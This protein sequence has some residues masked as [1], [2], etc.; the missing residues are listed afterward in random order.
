MSKL[1]IFFLL[2]LLLGHLILPHR[3]LQVS[4]SH[5]PAWKS[6][7]TL[8]VAQCILPRSSVPPP[9]S[10]P[11]Q[12]RNPD[13]PGLLYFPLPTPV[14]CPWLRSILTVVRPA[15][16]WALGHGGK[17]DGRPPPRPRPRPAALTALRYPGTAR[18]VTART[19][20]TTTGKC[21]VLPRR[22]RSC[23]KGRVCGTWG[24]GYVPDS[25][26]PGGRGEAGVRVGAAGVDTRQPPRACVGQTREL[27]P[28]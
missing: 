4:Y 16:G 8:G 18:A 11:P 1:R 20:G 12:S 22:G 28:F 9:P 23:L 5:L 21:R 6:T 17:R 13:R 27:R 24:G 26:S 15:W 10:P 7:V 19:A 25:C 3:W 2:V 14:P